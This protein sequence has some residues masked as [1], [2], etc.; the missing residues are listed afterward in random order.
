MKVLVLVLVVAVSQPGLGGI[1]TRSKCTTVPSNLCA[2]VYDDEKCNGWALNINE[3]EVDIF[4]L[5]QIFF[6]FTSDIFKIYHIYFPIHQTL[7]ISYIY[8]SYLIRYIFQIM[9]KWWDPV[10]Y[11]YRNDIE[12]VSVRKGCTFTGFDD[13]SLNGG[14]FTIRSGSGADTSVVSH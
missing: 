9:F 4:Y 5:H 14:S 8:F 7:F 3:G 2:V 12:S 6:Q 11:W 13:S 1:F 10:L